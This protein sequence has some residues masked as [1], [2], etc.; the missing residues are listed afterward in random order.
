MLEEDDEDNQ[1][2]ET[3]IDRFKDKSQSQQRKRELFELR[4]KSGP[5]F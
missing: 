4:F 3:V 2:S 5:G 1:M